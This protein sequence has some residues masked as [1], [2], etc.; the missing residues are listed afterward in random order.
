[1]GRGAYEAQVLGLRAAL[2]AL[3]KQPLAV[4]E[5]GKVEG[6]PLEL[7]HKAMKKFY[8][9]D[10]VNAFDLW[11]IPNPIL[12]CWLCT[13]RPGRASRRFGSR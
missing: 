11:A 1:M 3:R 12:E 10:E 8:K 5:D 6:E 4:D 9:S 7:A 2:V 13:S